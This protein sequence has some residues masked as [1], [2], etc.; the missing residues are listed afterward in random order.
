MFGNACRTIRDADH[1]GSGRRR[2]VGI[3]G[4]HRWYSRSDRPGMQDQ[5]ARREEK[6]TS[7]G[8]DRIATGSMRSAYGTPHNR[9]RGSVR[10]YRL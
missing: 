2:I 9:T 6:K 3:A 10:E 5:Y 4:L 8:H 1:L 7:V